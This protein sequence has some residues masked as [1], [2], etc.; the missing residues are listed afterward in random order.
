MDVPAMPPAR[1]RTEEPEIVSD[2]EVGIDLKE[3]TQ[4]IMA[5]VIAMKHLRLSN[6]QA[7]WGLRNTILIRYYMY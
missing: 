5:V 6:T 4:M 7:R 3:M 2:G 1:R